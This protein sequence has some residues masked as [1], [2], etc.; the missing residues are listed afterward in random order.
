MCVVVLSSRAESFDTMDSTDEAKRELR[1]ENDMVS[2]RFDVHAHFKLPDAAPLGVT[3]ANNFK[4]SPMANWSPEM[5]L[6]FMDRHGIAT[7]MLSVP[8]ALSPAVARAANTYCAQVVKQHPERFGLLASLP[9]TDIDAALAEIEFAFE[10]LGADGVVMMTNYADDYLGNPKFE[11]VFAALDH[12]HATVFIHPAAPAGYECVA[13][14]RPGP[15]IEFPFDTCRAVTDMLYAGILDRFSSISFIL[16]HAGGALP[17]LSHRIASLGTVSYVPHPPEMTR[18]TVLSQLG[19]LYFDTAIAGS[20]SSLGPV[21]E[22]TGP[23]HIVF[24]TDFPPATEAVII[25]NIEALD[26]LPGLN[27]EARAAINHNG[28]CLFARFRGVAKAP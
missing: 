9:M 27:V 28:C 20:I 8:S 24:G 3:P 15:V 23:D 21:L 10:T 6:E 18:Q 14:G 2:G 19:K 22:L 25:E 16:S 7:Q 5:A 11:K 12:R 4:A 13:C 17:A 26:G 1:G